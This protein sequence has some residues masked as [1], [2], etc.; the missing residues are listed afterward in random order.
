MSD[1]SI[2][3]A[4]VDVHS[5][6][7]SGA[8]R[9][10]GSNERILCQSCRKSLCE[11]QEGQLKQKAVHSYLAFVLKRRSETRALNYSMALNDL[12]SVVVTKSST[13]GELTGIYKTALNK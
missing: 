10:D 8:N 13:F 3:T 2:S 4:L 6:Y 9:F 5:A 11:Y 1:R 7:P 12:H